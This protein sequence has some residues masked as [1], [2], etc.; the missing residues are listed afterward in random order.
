MGVGADVGDGVGVDDGVG[1]GVNFNV[2]DS[3]SDVAPLI[4]DEIDK[5]GMT[6]E[7]SFRNTSFMSEYSRK[8]LD[9]KYFSQYY[10]HGNFR[11]LH[12]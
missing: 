5:E 12:H 1:V 4:I 3:I 8:C 11:P 2:D 7:V 6:T 9:L 10:I